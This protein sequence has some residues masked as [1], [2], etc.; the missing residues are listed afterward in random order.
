[1]LPAADQCRPRL[2]SDGDR[3]LPAGPGDYLYV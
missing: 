3:V 1:M 2:P